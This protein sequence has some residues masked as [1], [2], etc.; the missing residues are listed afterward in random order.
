M[1][2][3]RPDYLEGHSSAVGLS[4]ILLQSRQ[5]F[6]LYKEANG[7]GLPRGSFDETFEL[8]GLDHIVNRGR[9][10]LEVALRFKHVQLLGTSVATDDC[11]SAFQSTAKCVSVG[12]T[13]KETMSSPH[14][15]S[16]GVTLIAWT[17]GYR[18]PRPN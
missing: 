14:V 13:V 4:R 7:S 17:C 16:H 3:D 18:K 1:I 12:K 6:R 10:N 5:V 11:M 9:R 8:Q 2:A 15:L